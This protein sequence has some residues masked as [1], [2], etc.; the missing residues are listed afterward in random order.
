[1]CRVNKW[2]ADDV[3]HSVKGEF[4]RDILGR[5]NIVICITLIYLFKF[6]HVTFHGVFYNIYIQKAV[7]ILFIN[8]SCARATGFNNMVGYKTCQW[9]TMVLNSVTSL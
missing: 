8:K 9:V 6:I 5:L 4:L 3:L 7:S 2:F 1:M